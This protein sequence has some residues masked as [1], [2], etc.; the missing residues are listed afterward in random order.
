MA[1]HA[2]TASNEARNQKDDKESVDLSVTNEGT[3]TT[4]LRGLNVTPS[5]TNRRGNKGQMER[6]G[7]A[8]QY[9]QLCAGAQAQLN[10]MLVSV[11]NGGRR[12]D[13]GKKDLPSLNIMLPICHPDDR[14]KVCGICF[15]YRVM[16]LL[17]LTPCVIT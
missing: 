1:R 10:N 7:T 6:Y 16:K 8:V 13:D 15:V 5:K 3:L 4:Q 9:I 14:K 17:I 12:S 2:S 11:N